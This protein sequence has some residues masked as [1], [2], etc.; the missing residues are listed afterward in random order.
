MG[1]VDDA[2][3]ELWTVPAGGGTPTRLTDHGGI[4]ANVQWSPDGGR[5]LYDCTA[6]PETASVA[7]RTVTADGAEVADVMTGDYLVYPPM[8]AWLSDGRIVRT[9]PWNVYNMLDLVVHDPATGIDTPLDTP[10]TGQIGGLMVFGMNSTLFEPRLLVDGDDDVLLYVQIGGRTE[11]HRISTADGADTTL[12]TGDASVAPVAVRGDTV[13]LARTT[14]A[15]PASLVALDLTDGSE[16]PASTLDR[17]WLATLPFTVHELHFAGE[18]GTPVEG[19]FLEPTVGEGPYATVLHVHGGPF[20]A[21]GHG[22]SMDDHLLTSAGY[23]VLKVNFRGSSGYGEDFSASLVEDWG[24]HDA[25]D[26]LAGLDHAVSLGL[27]DPERLGSFGLSGGGFMT[28][29]L[30]THSD[31]FSAG[32]AEC[33]VTDW[34]GM[35]GSDIPQVVGRWLGS[36]PGHGPEAMAK[37]VRVSPATYAA[38][39]TTPMLVIEHE[40]DL[41]CPTGQ[42]DVLYNALTLAGCPTEMLRLPGMYHVDVYGVADLVGRTERLAALTEWFGRYLKP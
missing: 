19:W 23:G 3:T 10:V 21:H 17:V 42:G 2:A 41:R 12:W 4:V 20:A 39:C 30:L 26:V 24:H 9:T 37:Y 22:F 38:S 18:D 14:F 34:N 32:I 6:E 31:R 40:A 29:W 36:E 15:D 13:L 16:Q 5:L 1:L 35:V 33:P 27:A 11:L 8:A 25:G 28:S 7:L